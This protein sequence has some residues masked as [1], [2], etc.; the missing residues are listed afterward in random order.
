MPLTE[1]G[2]RFSRTRLFG[3]TH[4]QGDSVYRLC[5]MRGLGSG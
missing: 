3:R 1:L 5:V 4:E 2:V